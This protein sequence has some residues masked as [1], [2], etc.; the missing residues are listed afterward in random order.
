MQFGGFVSDAAVQTAS[1][2]TSITFMFATFPSI[3]CVLI[4]VLAF[5]YD[6]DGVKYTNIEKAIKS[7]NFG[8]NR[9]ESITK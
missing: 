3:L 2:L 6:L 5:L 9:D 1:A 7:G 8:K 4:L